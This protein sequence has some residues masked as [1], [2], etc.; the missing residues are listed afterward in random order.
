ME[1]KPLPDLSTLSDAELKELIDDLKEAERELSMQRRV[2]HGRIDMLREELVGRLSR[3]DEGA[4]S[5]VDVDALAQIL[6]GRLTEVER[7]EGGPGDAA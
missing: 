6:A 4:L 1:L 7:L 2:L 5:V 3:K